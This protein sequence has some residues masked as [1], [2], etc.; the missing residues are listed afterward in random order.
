MISHALDE[1]ST[2]A[3]VLH[4]RPEGLGVRPVP[5]RARRPACYQPAGP[6]HSLPLSGD[7]LPPLLADLGRMLWRTLGYT[8][9]RI[10]AATQEIAARRPLASGGAR[11]P[12]DLS[13]VVAP[14]TGGA[15]GAVA[16]RVLHYAPQYHRLFLDSDGGAVTAAALGL[17]ALAAGT[18]L[19]V[20]R[21]DFLRTWEKY[22][23]FAYRLSAV[24][25][26]LVIG[27]LAALAARMGELAIDV[28]F[29]G[30]QLDRVLGLDQETQASYCVLRLVPRAGQAGRPLLP[31]AH[32]LAPA[33]VLPRSERLSRRL[34]EAHRLAHARPAAA[35]HGPAAPFLAFRDAPEP[36]WTAL[37]EAAADAGTEE[38]AIAARTSRAHAFTGQAL[39]ASTLRACVDRVRHSLAALQDAS[40]AA[41]ELPQLLVC[42]LNVQGVAAGAYA[43]A[44]DGAA[45]RLIAPGPT[46]AALSE[47][48][49]LQSLDIRK[50]AFV[51]HVVGRTWHSDAA[52]GARAY[53]IA[54]MLAGAALDAAT[55]AVSAPG[56]SA[57]A[58]LGFDAAR[59]AA[60]YRLAPGS[61]VGAQLCVGATAAGCEL[62]RSLAC[63]GAQ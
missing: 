51:L 10:D 7:S 60:L 44:G 45:L 53:R 49:L 6:C 48:L 2:F 4:G 20:V 40:A 21:I 47:A 16:G 11:Y 17:D 42:C 33:P 61:T 19:L 37:P 24:D 15:L 8:Q 55:L 39:P 30:P 52:R 36:V 54:Q 9:L 50:S 31:Q 62:T 57:H 12:A 46:G 29:D 63:E 18:L 14:G 41:L 23:D 25:T 26:G 59:L 22:G 43:L 1:F 38:Q 32:A 34:R 35:Q 3:R 58:Y 28:D 13:V 27:R 5:A 56:V